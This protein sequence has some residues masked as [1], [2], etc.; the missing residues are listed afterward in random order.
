MVMVMLIDEPALAQRQ[1]A[2]KS[3]NRIRFRRADAKAEIKRGE[4]D[5]AELL[6]APPEWMLT[7]K[8]GDVVLWEPGVGRWRAGRILSGLATPAARVER[9]GEPTRRR[10]ATRLREASPRWTP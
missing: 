8:I 10:I 1:A 2:L 6:L 7:A 4:L 9:L 5:L 3:A